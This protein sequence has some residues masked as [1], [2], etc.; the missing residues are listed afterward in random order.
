RY[1]PI[2]Q[3]VRNLHAWDKR[4]GWGLPQ[5]WDDRLDVPTD[6]AALALP[7]NRLVSVNVVAFLE[8]KGGVLGEHRTF[9]AYWD[10][11]KAQH[12]NQYRNPDLRA[13]PETLRL[14]PGI[15]HE[16]G[17]RIEVID[18]GANW[19]KTVGLKPAD[20]RSP[21]TSPH[22]G[23]LAS[24]AQHP[25]RIRRMDGTTVPFERIAGYQ[26]SVPGH[27]PWRDVPL[28]DW[29]R[30]DRQVRLGVGWGG[31][32]NPRCSVPVVRRSPLGSGTR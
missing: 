17:V 24:V 6:L 16:P 11:I 23:L 14:L 3:Q 19:E 28:W 25:K 4:Y 1:T 13:T 18:H 7:E 26:C 30:G 2:E 12:P 15:T 8:A 21:E 20:V 5:G 31:G 29:Y 22:A 10:I 9:D 32:P 27:D